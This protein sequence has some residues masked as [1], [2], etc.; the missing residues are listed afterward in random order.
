MGRREVEKPTPESEEPTGDIFDVYADTQSEY[1]T[2][3]LAI[4]AAE[5]ELL[6]S[7]NE[8]AAS[9]DLE[10]VAMIDREL[11]T[12]VWMRKDLRRVSF[13]LA[14]T[15]HLMSDEAVVAPEMALKNSAAAG[16]DSAPPEPDQ[17]VVELN[18]SEP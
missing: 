18:P 16:T 13:V 8:F 1:D 3:R 10:A 7:R 15:S 17:P 2:A 9:G 14:R 6:N 5:A 4:D 11:Q 12:Y